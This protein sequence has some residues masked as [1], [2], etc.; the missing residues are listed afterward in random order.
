MTL[1]DLL[2]PDDELV[3][4]IAAVGILMSR[5][6]VAERNPDSKWP[7]LHLRLLPRTDTNFRS[8]FVL[9]DKPYVVA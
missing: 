4:L 3:Q 7:D 5:N 9:T 6:S 1:A 8:T 2:R